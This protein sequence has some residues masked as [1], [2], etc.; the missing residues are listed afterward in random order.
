M[1][2]DLKPQEESSQI[3][4]R[5]PDGSVAAVPGSVLRVLHLLWSGTTGG[6]ERA[7]YQLVREQ[8][9]GSTVQPAV[10]F[11][12]PGGPYE[13]RLI[14]LGCPVEVL[15]LPNARSLRQLT[16]ARRAMRGYD[17]HHFHAAE[18]LLMAASAACP[19]VA[20]VYTHRGG[21]SDRSF[22]RQARFRL[23]GP[24][25]RRSFHAYSGNTAHGAWS[26]AKL[27][28][29]DPARFHVTYNGIE[30]SLLEPVRPAQEVR[31]EL[32]VTTEFV[33]GTA[34]IL[35]DWKRVDRLVQALP[36]MRK[37][38]PVC[39]LIVGDGPERARLED[40]ARQLG[41]GSDVIFAGLQQHVAD[42]LQVMDV[43]CLPSSGRES[44][45]N[46]VTEAMVAGVPPVVFADSPGLAEHIEHGRTG[47]IVETLE[48][49]TAV[50]E[51]LRADPALRKAIGQ[52]ASAGIRARYTLARS[53]RAYEALYESAMERSA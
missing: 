47:F 16:V 42:Y 13:E 19:G 52:D 32:G 22:G 34:A 40:L 46:A 41:V 23:A 30:F 6:L 21:F 44:F 31:G 3:R 39:L 11:A 10:L 27:M 29:I 26:G 4:A 50:L 43:F 5:P 36:A 38:G 1:S 49:L 2:P 51:R 18:P 12:G 9:A 24:V 7:V 20:R 25:V 28:K 8:L 33:F 35:K 14:D 53:A 15:G 37:V 48:E 17:V 45:G